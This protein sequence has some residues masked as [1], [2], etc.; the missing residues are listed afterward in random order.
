[1]RVIKHDLPNFETLEIVV[2]ADEHLGDPLSDARRVK[3]TV[4]YVMAAENRFMI[5][6]G[7]LMDAAIK[8]SIGDVYGAVLTPMQQLELCVNIFGKAKSRIL[9]VGPG[10]HELRI[11]KQD[12][13]D[14]TKLMCQELGLLKVYTPTSG[15]IF[16]RFGASAS[17]KHHNNP[18]LYRIYANHG[19]G[20][21][22]RKEGGKINRLAD[23]T[24]ICDADIY[25]HSHTH[26][27][28]IFMDSY[29]R[30]SSARSTISSHNRLFVNTAANL[31]Y[32]GYAE[33]CGY[34]PASLA[35]P[36]IT[37]SGRQ[38]WMRGSIE[39]LVTGAEIG[40]EKK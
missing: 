26:L 18:I 7:D 1:M 12:G 6:N 27:P 39:A 34:P 22:G 3:E 28:A 31:D 4:A 13:I 14:M 19:G 16:L 8:S 30:P 23:M 40:K 17:T 32:G 35:N 10:N 11:Y 29:Y 15:Y 24:R 36:L 38:E 37:L 2:V 25:I 9:L 21:G 5:L 33:L 20:G